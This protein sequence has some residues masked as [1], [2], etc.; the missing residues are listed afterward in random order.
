MKRLLNTLYVIT[1]GSYLSRDGET[2][3][4][5]VEKETMLRVPIHTLDGII[6]F[7]RVS[8]SP[9]LMGLCGERGVTISFL[10]ENGRFWARVQG[11]VSGNVLLRRE[12]YRRAD[13][14][15]ASADIARAVVIAKVANSRT[16]LKRAIRDHAD[17]I[18]VASLNDA[19]IRL[20]RIGES[21]GRM[22]PL[23]IIRG[24]EGEAA[25][26]YFAVFDNLIVG[27][28]EDFKLHDRSRRPPLDNVNA[29]LS[30]LYTLLAHDVSSALESVGLDPAVGYL[31]RDRPGR[32][33]LALD[34]ME[35]FR[36]FIADRLALSLINRQQVKP[37]GFSKSETNAIT[38]NDATRKQ[39]LVAYQKRKQEELRHPFIEEKVPVGLL[40]YV[41]ALL[42][43]RYLRGE[44]DAYPPFLWR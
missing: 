36:A 2:V 16:V 42:L 29:L 13:D 38:M 39:V 43:S 20:S 3:L 8:C 37:D 6:C 12:Q 17:G 10:S 7:G 41:Q 1:Q 11:P 9:H 5:R 28:K 31:H 14:S 40:P 34:V 18:D 32:P 23:E 35:E 22:E 44:L 24:R 15:K 25:R 27:Q 4:V 19:V 21:L 30:F 33:G 26:V